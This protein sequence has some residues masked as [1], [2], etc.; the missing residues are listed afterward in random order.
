MLINYKKKN[1]KNM[2]TI[3]LSVIIPPE[4][5]RDCNIFRIMRLTICLL[6]LFTGLA[7][8]ENV[9]SRN[10]RVNLNQQEV[11]LKDVLKEIEQ[12]TGKRVTGTITDTN[13]EAIIGANVVEKGTTNGSI[14]DVDGKFVLSVSE[15]AVLIISY[16]GYVAQEVAVR[17]LTNVQ[18]ELKEDS[19]SIDEIV[20]VG[21]G[22]Q[23]KVNLT[24]SVNTVQS[25]R[26]ENKPVTSLVSALTGEAAGVTITQRSGQPGPNQGDIR[27]RGIGTWGNAAPLVLV[28][29][30]SMSINDVVPSEVES[31]SVL[32]D[33][34]SASIYGSRAANGV[35]LIT[36]KQGA[37]GKFKLSYDGN[38]GLQTTTRIPKMA[39]SWEFAELYN[40][41]MTNVGKSSDLYPPDRIERMKA[42]G[43]PDKL[44][45]NTDW[46]KE[47]LRTSI[48]QIHQVSITGGN[49]R[50]SYAGILGYSNQEGVIPTT[51]YDRYNARINTKSQLTPW[52]N[53]VFNLA[54]LNSTQKETAD[55]AV[56]AFQKIARSLPNMPVKYSDGTWSFLSAPTNAVRRVTEDYGMRNVLNNAIMTQISPEITPVKGLLIKGVLGYESNTTLDKTFNKIV[57]YAAFEPAGQPGII[58]V[59]RNKQTDKWSLYRNLTVNTSATYEF[60]LGANS[61]K[62]MAGASAES[63]KY[64][65]TLASRQDFPN[66]DFTE[67]NGGDPNTSAAEG[68]STLSSLVSLF[69]RL[70]YIYA[71]KYL[72]EANFRYDGSSKF[73]RGHRFGLFP[74]F[75][76]GWRISEEAFF[77]DLKAT[78]PNLKLRGS[79]GKLGNQQIDNYQYISTFG[80][81]GSYLFNG[82]INTGY[83]EVVMGNPAIT[84]ETATSYN[85]GIDF[86]LLDDRLQTVFD[87]YLK[88]T[89]DILLSLKAPATLGISPSMQNAGSVENKG[90]E[91]AVNWQDKIGDSFHY[92]VGFNLSDVQNKITDLRGYK[93][94]SDGLTT[95]IE[96]EPI[97]A[98]FGWETAGLCVTQ[99]QYDQYKDL[100]QT[101]NTNWNIGDLIIVDRNKDGK[102]G[103]DDKTVIGNQIPR[104]GYG[105][106]LGF[107]YKNIDFSCF[108]QGVG[109]ADGYVTEE[110]VKALGVYS[111]RHDQYTDSFNPANPN[112]KAYFPRMTNSFEYNYGNMSHWVQDASYLRLKNLQLGYTF[113]LTRLGIE[114][115]RLMLSGEN[116]FTVTKF[117]A[118]DPETQVGSRNMYP[119]V[120]I[121]S[122]GVNATF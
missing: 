36:T 7:F 54:Y 71:D 2:K 66:N 74:S 68:N 18:V 62:V 26:I 57:E 60:D 120:A 77:E 13:G 51:A 116:L 39:T 88:N 12:Q 89:E 21:Y 87:W 24:G 43:D 108:F 52:F 94:P 100:M 98:I 75:S 9:H 11:I 117:R 25:E 64:A 14:T 107:D 37:K 46:Y 5:N 96:G 56:N 110:L 83:A 109:K 91:I 34:A 63:F 69:G 61:F 40:Q 27:I 30:I 102:I 78:I 1:A 17:N 105:I 76:V 80:S 45:G 42:G 72:F 49:D 35:V 106:N 59:S 85:I 113:H 101:Y 31:V 15:N 99:E 112:P 81:N 119:L 114:R 44:E 115:L 50:F 82:A 55:G 90:W 79:W 67:I 20:V 6:L 118:W 70:N 97:D 41:S 122:F 23:K 65:Y 92:H 58:D 32:K 53:L 73:A 22:T 4:N 86:S 95:R 38:L 33:A 19:Q 84:W 10:A 47:F 16:I 121:Y 28:D 111:A 93:S 48:Q 3:F 8:A 104:F 29:G 103:A